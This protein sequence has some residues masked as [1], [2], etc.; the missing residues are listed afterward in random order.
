[1]IHVNDQTPHNNAIT[2]TT[3]QYCVVK[4]MQHPGEYLY[5]RRE[6]KRPHRITSQVSSGRWRTI[7]CWVG[8]RH[9]YFYGDAGS[10]R[11]KSFALTSNAG[12]TANNQERTKRSHTTNAWPVVRN[13]LPNQRKFTM[14][15]P[16]DQMMTTKKTLNLA[17]AHDY[18]N[19]ITKIQI[20]TNVLILV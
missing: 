17:G 1:M 8:P 10:I 3:T 12:T 5:L 14:N 15:D 4:K 19:V 20:T 11:S 16:L 7:L 9:D 18:V 6:Q 2:K 13:G